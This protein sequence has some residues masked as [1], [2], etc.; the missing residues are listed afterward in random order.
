MIQR[1]LNQKI[2]LLTAANDGLSKQPALRID[3]VTPAQQPYTKAQTPNVQA[4]TA[5]STAARPWE[6]A[7]M[8]YRAA[9]GTNLSES[10]RA[11]AYLSPFGI[12]EYDLIHVLLE[13]LP[14]RMVQ[15]LH[16]L[17]KV[18]ADPIFY[19]EEL[20]DYATCKPTEPQLNQEHPC[21]LGR[22]LNSL[23]GGNGMLFSISFS[24]RRQLML[25]RS[26]PYH[27]LCELCSGCPSP[28][29][30]QIRQ[31][32]HRILQSDIYF[33][34]VEPSRNV[35]RKFAQILSYYG[36]QDN[37]ISNHLQINVKYLKRLKEEETMPQQPLSSGVLNSDKR[38]LRRDPCVILLNTIALNFYCILQS[39][40]MDT[41]VGPRTLLLQ[42]PP[43]NPNRWVAIAAYDCMR[44]L[45][46]LRYFAS[47]L[48]PQPI[49]MPS[50]KLFF[51]TLQLF[52]NCGLR[53][54][55]CDSLDAAQ[56][57]TQHCYSCFMPA[58]ISSDKRLEQWHAIPTECPI[59]RLR[60]LLKDLEERCLHHDPI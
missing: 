42:P 38:D 40:L 55:N 53:L 12:S 49:K 36:V 47:W 4:A 8:P 23:L 19:T 11:D 18:F 58:F 20:L 9:A 6:Y 34:P 30:R 59:C 7:Q 5:R 28:L 35:V 60:P 26:S 13:E 41:D 31:N 39:E 56:S 32:L 25:A 22:G 1:E 24:V 33:R 14:H 29:F 10:E 48:V 2:N 44:S 45:L 16:L 37:F 43:I 21:A 52:H 15:Q 3:K 17:R 46:R 51:R 57:D 54:H 27:L 50:Y